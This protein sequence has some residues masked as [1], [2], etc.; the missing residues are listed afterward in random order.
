MPADLTDLTWLA[1][2]SHYGHRGG[3]TGRAD[4]GSFGVGNG[5]AFGIVGL[6]TPRN[7][8]TNAIGPDYQ[9]NDGFFG[10]ADL[11][12]VR[13]GT[14]LSFE[15][16]VVQ[17]P[18]GAPVVRTWGAVGDLSLT[19]TDTVPP[20][21]PWILR[22][23][24]VRN[25]GSAAETVEV[26]ITLAR[27]AGESVVEDPRGLR[28]DR[29]DKHMLVHCPGADLSIGLSTLRIALPD[30]P[31]GEEVSV[32][33]LHQ[34]SDDD[35][36]DTP[37]VDVI[38]A[39]EAAR[40]SSTA[41]LERAVVLEVPDPK[42]TDLVE[43]MLITHQVQTSA[44]GVVSPMH[45]YTKG[46]MRDTEGP[47]RLFLRA[48][49]HEEVRTA[50]DVTYEVAVVQHAITNS[51]P[52]DT[53]L[54][55]FEE[56]ADP[57]GF[58]VHASFM[59]GRN[60]VE[61]P[62][63]P[64]WLHAAY[65]RHT[66]DDGVLDPAR[67]AFLEAC[68]SRQEDEDGLMTFSGDE[69]FRFALA[70]ATGGGMPE[71]LG[72][73]S[74]SA[75]WFVAAAEQL[76][77]LGGDPTLAERAAT[78][79]ETTDATYLVNG[80]YSPLALFEDRSPWPHPFEDVT[81]MPVWTGYLRPDDPVAVDNVDQ[82]VEA[83]MRED[84]TLLTPNPATGEQMP[85]Y[86]GMVPRYLLYNLAAQHRPEAE[87]AFNALDRVATPSGH[88]EEAHTPDN[89]V[90][91]VIHDPSGLGGD[92]SARYRPWEGGDVVAALL[93]YL[94]GEEVDAL[95]GSIRLAPHLPNGWPWLA[96]RGLRVGEDRYDL[97][98]SAWEEGREVRVTREGGSG[99]WTLSV[100]LTGD[101]SF[102]QVWVDGER[103][104]GEEGE[105]PV[106]E[107]LVLGPGNTVVVVG[108]Y[109]RE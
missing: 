26:Q 31:A 42:V 88:F 23:I 83:L 109:A 16:E 102:R 37:E 34:F 103:W 4:A 15:E 28:Q 44:L 2:V 71:S 74:N 12:L 87:L 91:E 82:M 13:A 49:L 99:E 76:A 60:P 55:S 84:G 80:F 106:V 66:G 18:R 54:S 79:R 77:D 3:S 64:V 58:W 59:P 21:R 36:F 94:V 89:T 56:P 62:S 105:N 108:A 63:Y 72:W 100:T 20:G 14:P 48:G 92:I 35:T 24:A 41:L 29:G 65:A 73:S 46:W 1:D 45:R 5:L 19:T 97:E 67:M 9:R 107:D 47:A 6:D 27:G 78:I 33:C 53:D 17:R 95:T 57:V 51:F 43:G 69:T 7:T 22:H 75:F 25:E 32:V 8:L 10:D 30:L 68:L 39:L 70:Y 104:S 40:A 93:A 38:A 61:A 98:V 50:L 81:P 90:W 86:T 96:A 52:L 85:A 11:R 101:R